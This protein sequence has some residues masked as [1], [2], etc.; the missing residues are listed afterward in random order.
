MT[1]LNIALIGECM[2]ELLHEG[3]NFR[4]GFGGDTLNT[5][6]Y[7]SRLTAGKGVNVSYVTALGQDKISQEMIDNWNAEG[8]NTQFV[9]RSATKQPGLYMVETDETGERSFIYWRNDAAA[10]FWLETASEELIDQLVA[11]DAIYLSGISVAILSPASREKLYDLLG[12]CKAAGGK[13][14]FDNNYR[15]K[16][17]NSAE[18][19]AESFKRIL[20]VTNTG[21]LTFD[22]EQALFGD[23]ELE[24]C[25]TRT[26][27]LGVEEI[28][29]KRGGGECMIVTADETI[30]VPA[31]KVANVVDTTAAGDSFAAGYMAK[32]VLGETSE[33]SAKK[34]H[35]LAGTVIQHKGALIDAQFTAPFVD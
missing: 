26:R 28:V 21:L 31:T 32:R 8:I 15:P 19:A 3:D 12:R 20:S 11:Q 2:I 35:Q 27:D 13:V 30:S 24:E 6:V 7:L 10:K 5:A 25:L 34:G 14:Y 1:D 29:I 17:W 16:L 18:E 23:V 4:Q 9:Q 22:D 33:V